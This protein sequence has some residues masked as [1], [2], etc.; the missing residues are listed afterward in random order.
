MSEC[1]ICDGTGCQFCERT[2]VLS[3]D[4]GPGDVTPESS[5]WRQAWVK[6]MPR[7]QGN[8]SFEVSFEAFTE[9]TTSDD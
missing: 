1:R 8:P 7:T 4:D 5:E 2:I 3:F 9:V 6:G